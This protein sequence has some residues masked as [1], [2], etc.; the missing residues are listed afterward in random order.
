MY[1]DPVEA[2]ASLISDYWG[3]LEPN[4]FRPADFRTHM[5]ISGFGND[6]LFI[7]K[8]TSTEDAH[9]LNWNIITEDV[10]IDLRFSTFS[11]ELLNPFEIQIRDIISRYNRSPSTSKYTN[12]GI[13]RMMVISTDSDILGAAGEE[14]FDRNM[15]IR[16]QRQYEVY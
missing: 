11:K 14:I 5:Y 16:V 1:D 12:T 3:T 4:S 7:W 6:I 2:I 13:L 9:P 15:S 10:I 8:R